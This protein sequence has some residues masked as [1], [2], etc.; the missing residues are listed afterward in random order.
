MAQVPALSQGKSRPG[1]FHCTR[2][3]DAKVLPVRFCR[4]PRRSSARRC[5]GVG[6]LG[7]FGM[8]GLIFVVALV[9][10]NLHRVVPRLLGLPR[11]V[12]LDSS[13]TDGRGGCYSYFT[14]DPFLVVRSQAV[15][16]SLP[17]RR[18]RPSWRPTL[19][20]PSAPA[21][22]LLGGSG[23]EPVAVLGWRHRLFRLRHRPA[24]GAG[25][26]HRRRRETARVRHRYL[27][28]GPSHRP[29]LR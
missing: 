12:Y 10:E 15:A 5:S 14:A 21:A 1:D 19:T 27:R 7:P 2:P 4:A 28:L 3:K 24:V 22:P 8:S 23:A 11:P 9:P 20:L 17:V 6:R 26:R 25:A 29:P 18:G 13:L 16:S